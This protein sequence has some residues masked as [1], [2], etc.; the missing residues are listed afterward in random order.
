MTRKTKRT[1]SKDKSMEN[2]V[3]L[4]D[5]YDEYINEFI[6]EKVSRLSGKGKR[7]RNNTLY[8]KHRN[9]MFTLDVKPVNSK[10][11]KAIKKRYKD[12]FG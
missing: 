1:K 4:D 8:I 12:Y 3:L 5:L 2:T 11:A 7:K 9:K 10:K 6:A